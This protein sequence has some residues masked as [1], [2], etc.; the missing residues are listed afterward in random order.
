ML[1]L[2]CSALFLLGALLSGLFI[3]FTRQA[4]FASQKRLGDLETGAQSQSSRDSANLRVHGPA[5]DPDHGHQFSEFVQRL[6]EACDR[7]IRFSS[8]ASASFRRIKWAVLVFLILSL[9][10]LFVMVLWNTTWEELVL[11]CVCAMICLCAICLANMHRVELDQEE[12]PL[13]P[14]KPQETVQNKDEIQVLLPASNE[15]Q[16]IR[17]ARDLNAL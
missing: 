7:F 11:L 12:F 10:A 2:F 13:K 6:L 3:V 4:R 17:K 14:S 8:P 5:N 1:V 15:K 9:V 16:E